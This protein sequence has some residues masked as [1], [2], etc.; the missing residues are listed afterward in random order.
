M[1]QTIDLDPSGIFGAVFWGVTAGILTSAILLMLG[2]VFTRIVVPWYQALLFQG[3]DLSGMW[4]YSQNLGGV[5]YDYLMTLTQKA[6]RL[7]GA[8]TLKKSGA[9]PGPRGD[10]VQAFDV[11]GST[12]EGF[13][14]LNMRSTDRRSLFATSLLQIADRGRSLV[15]QLVYRSSQVDQVDSERVS[16]LRG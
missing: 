15:G 5:Q 14:T 12:W 10:Y 16:W 9:P 6:H 7:S 11:S 13:V 4:V 2:L 8:M 1:I 3:V